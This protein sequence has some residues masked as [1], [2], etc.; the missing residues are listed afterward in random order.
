MTNSGKVACVIVGILLMNILTSGE[1]C[2]YAKKR[3]N[4]P[5]KDIEYKRA[6]RRKSSE[7][8]GKGY[9]SVEDAFEISIRPQNIRGKLVRDELRD[10]KDS[11]GT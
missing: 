1:R 7:K 3:M 5:E 8:R 2:M 4:L 10:Q 6:A 9:S 11:G